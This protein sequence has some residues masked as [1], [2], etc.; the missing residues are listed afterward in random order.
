LRHDA[1]Q[2]WIVWFGLVWF[3]LVWFGL[4]WLACYNSWIKSQSRTVRIIA[5]ASVV[6]FFLTLI[7]LFIFMVASALTG[8]HSV[9]YS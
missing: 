2:L 3:G 9:R 5:N 4:V 1:N 6:L 8:H 7:V